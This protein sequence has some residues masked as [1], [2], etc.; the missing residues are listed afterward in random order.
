MKRHDERPA[1]LIVNNLTPPDGD[2][3]LSLIV[4]KCK[5][6]SDVTVTGVLT[7]VAAEHNNMRW[8]GTY[9]KEP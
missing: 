4:M 3:L 5:R 7:P 2:I 8:Q 1:G 6:S 9:K